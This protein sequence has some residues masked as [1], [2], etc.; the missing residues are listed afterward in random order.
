M[1]YTVKP[2]KKQLKLMKEWWEELQRVENEF[3]EA[4]GKLDDGMERETGIE[5]IEFFRNDFG[6]F[7]G[8]GTIDRKMKLIFGEGL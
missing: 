5:G 3:Y 6:E 2:T 7:V 8:V 4:V 1:R